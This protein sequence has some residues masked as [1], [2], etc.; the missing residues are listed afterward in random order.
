MTKVGIW[1]SR[2][3]MKRGDQY[4]GGLTH[5]RLRQDRSSAPEHV[6][7]E[8]CGDGDVSQAVPHGPSTW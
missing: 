3:R 6:D 2:I 7:D 4:M 5:A 8:V 1:G